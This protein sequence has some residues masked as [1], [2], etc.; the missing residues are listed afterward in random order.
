MYPAVQPRLAVLG[1]LRCVAHDFACHFGIKCSSFS[2]MNVG[3]SRRSAC[4]ALGYLEYMSVQLGNI[5]CERTGE[6]VAIYKNR[7]AIEIIE[8]VA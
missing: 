6:F 7:L 8:M 5:L 4:D 3:T 1:L 2:K